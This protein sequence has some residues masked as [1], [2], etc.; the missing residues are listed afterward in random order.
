MLAIARGLMA[1]PKILLLDEP[2]L[3]LAP[4][5]VEEIFETLYQLKQTIRDYYHFSRTKRQSSP[6]SRRLGIP[7]GKRQNKD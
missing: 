5:I 6:A 3:G 2:S 4:I 1:R 7:V